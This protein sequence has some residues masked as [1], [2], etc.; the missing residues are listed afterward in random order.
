MVNICFRVDAGKKIGMGHLM[1]SIVLADSLKKR[2]DCNI[3]FLTKNFSPAVNILKEK[4]YHVKK[5][6]KDISEEKEIDIILKFIKK[7][8]IEILIC[9]LLNKNT[10][11]FQTLKDSSQLLVV[12]LDDDKHGAIP[13]DIVVNFSIAQNKKFY[14]KFSKSKAL[15]CIDPEYMLLPEILHKE[16][17]KKKRIS[18]ISKTIF[19]NQG[20]EDPH[21]LTSKIIKSLELLDLKQKIIVVVGHAVSSKHRKELR[22][23]ESQLKNVYQFEWDV[24]QGQMYKFMAESD[25]AITA[26]GNTLYELA[27][28]GVPSIVI[29]HHKLH[30]T[31]AQIF[32]RKNAVINLGIGTDIPKELIADSLKDLLGNK[33]KRVSLSKNAKRI[34]DGLG[35]E[36]LSKII[37]ST[38][39]DKSNMR[40]MAL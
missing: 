34:T 2:K 15:Y 25:I 28:F 8:N 31:V 22:S 32:A 24:T 7:S 5:L 14:K 20:G 29:G 39:I 11:Y 26:A 1:E 17:K 4:N 40:K 19:I 21:G 33:K 36:R 30:D 18:E 38:S 3:L 37:T 13:G 16:W 9:D 27:I 23:L 35:S 10:D 6:D 12:I